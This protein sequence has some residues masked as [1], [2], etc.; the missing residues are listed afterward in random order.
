MGY[1]IYPQ[2]WEAEIGVRVTGRRGE[3]Q[4]ERL[5]RIFWKIFS[6]D[7]VNSYHLPYSVLGFKCH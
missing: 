3:G 1:L 2:E 6:A 4:P 5:L 7:N